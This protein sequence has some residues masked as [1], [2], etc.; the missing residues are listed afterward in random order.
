MIRLGQGRKT[1]GRLV[2]LT[3]YG[4]PGWLNQDPSFGFKGVLSNCAGSGGDVPL[5]RWIKNREETLGD[6]IIDFPLVGIE[7]GCRFISGDN[8]KVVTDLFV[9]ENSLVFLVYPTLF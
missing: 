6:Q 9:V 1:V 7:G 3:V 4:Q 8:R 5:S 2:V